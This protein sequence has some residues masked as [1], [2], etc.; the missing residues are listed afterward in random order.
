MTE[1]GLYRLIFKARTHDKIIEHVRWLPDVLEV[2]D[3]SVNSLI[4]NLYC[5]P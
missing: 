1:A 3:L 5:K 2:I 4:K